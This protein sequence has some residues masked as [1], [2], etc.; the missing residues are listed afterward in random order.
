MI[1]PFLVT[2]GCNNGGLVVFSMKPITNIPVLVTIGEYDGWPISKSTSPAVVVPFFFS[3]RLDNCRLVVFSVELPVTKPPL[4][5]RAY[6][7]RPTISSMEFVVSIPVGYSIEYY[8]RV[9][10]RV[11]MK[12]ASW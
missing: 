7:G 8:R 11:Y 2:T 12:L 5:I 6:L 9:V 4:A 3:S 1:V 10:T